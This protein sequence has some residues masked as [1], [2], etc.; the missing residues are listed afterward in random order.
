M[1]RTSYMS[2]CVCMHVLVIHS[3]SKLEIFVI[4]SKAYNQHA[5]ASTTT[6]IVPNLLF[7]ISTIIYLE[8]NWI[9]LDTNIPPPLFI[10]DK[11]NNY[12]LCCTA[13]S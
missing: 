4:K 11:K 10:I 9:K 1:H 6:T 12:I 5:M 13:S 8:E 7:V 3:K 2:V